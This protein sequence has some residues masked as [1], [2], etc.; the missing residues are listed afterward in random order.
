MQERLCESRY[1]VL[2]WHIL[3]LLLC[4]SPKSLL[5]SN[6]FSCEHLPFKGFV[7]PLSSN[8]PAKTLCCSHTKITNPLLLVSFFSYP[9]DCI[10][11]RSWNRITI[12]FYT[13]PLDLSWIIHRDFSNLVTSLQGMLFGS[14]AIWYSK[15]TSQ[16]MDWLIWPEVGKW[17]Y[18]QG[19]LWP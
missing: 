3:M 7:M 5:L 19:I 14:W 13:K 15:R 1:V 16:G 11:E 2:L 17:R 18:L 10:P 8:V 9:A 12:W 6:V 4:H